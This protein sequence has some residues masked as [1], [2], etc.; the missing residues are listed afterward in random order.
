MEH[1]GWFAIGYMLMDV[2]LKA[3]KTIRLFLKI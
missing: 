3:I 2:F 1:F